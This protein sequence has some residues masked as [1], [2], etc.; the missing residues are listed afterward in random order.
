V[1]NKINFAESESGVKFLTG[2]RK[3]AL[4]TN[5]YSVTEATRDDEAR[6][7]RVTWSDVSDGEAV[8]G[9]RLTM[10]DEHGSVGRCRR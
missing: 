8:E 4:L 6:T 2:S 9:K 5:C 10:D 1:Y 7:C 3:T